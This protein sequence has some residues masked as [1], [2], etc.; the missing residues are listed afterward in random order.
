MQHTRRLQQQAQP[1]G[2]QQAPSGL[3]EAHPWRTHAMPTPTTTSATEARMGADGRFPK[4]KNSIT[5]VVGMSMSF[6]IWG[7]RRGDGETP[8]VVLLSARVWARTNA[9]L[10]A[11]DSGGA[12][13]A[14]SFSLRRHLIEPH[15]VEVEGQVGE[16]EGPR[17]EEGENDD[18]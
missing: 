6:A 2:T 4:T 14:H 11:P 12:E 1:R 10:T 7:A 15:A 16:A 13:A 9:K 18:V 3:R 8:R 5:Q 17:V